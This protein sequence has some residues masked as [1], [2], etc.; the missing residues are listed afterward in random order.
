MKYDS[1]KPYL[2]AIKHIWIKIKKLELRIVQKVYIFHAKD[3]NLA[4]KWT[5]PWKVFN[6]LTNVRHNSKY[7]RSHIKVC[8]NTLNWPHFTKKE[9]NIYLQNESSN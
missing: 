1:T 4:V 2:R 3:E 6:R 9:E 5:Q 7:K 8:K